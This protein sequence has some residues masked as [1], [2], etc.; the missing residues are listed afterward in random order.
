MSVAP[1]KKMTEEEY[2]ALERTAEFKSEFLAGE[3]YA[4]TGASRPHTLIVTNAVR[5]L[6][7]QLKGRSCEVY[8][9]DMRVRVEH[10]GLYTYPDI[11]VVCGEPRLADEHLD[12]LLNPTVIIEVLSPSTEAYDRGTKFA[13]YR[14]LPSLRE[15]VLV[16]QTHAHVERFVRQDGGPEWT[17]S[18]VRG[19][20]GTLTLTSIGCTL[21]L[22][23]LYDR[24]DVSDAPLPLRL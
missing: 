14:E 16:S 3:M 10:T 19:Q 13:H 18:A 17:L 8:V 20:G 1:Q 22:A 4:M 23:E 11:V 7:N 2:L 15:Y 12:T 9:A 24:V 5:E 21:P 6:G